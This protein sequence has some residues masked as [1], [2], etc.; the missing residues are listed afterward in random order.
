MPFQDLNFD[1][2]H[3]HI[4]K[5]IQQTKNDSRFHFNHFLKD[6][7]IDFLVSNSSYSLSDIDSNFPEENKLRTLSKGSLGSKNRIECR[8]YGNSFS[9][10]NLVNLE[11]LKNVEKLNVFVKQNISRKENNEILNSSIQEKNRSKSNSILKS[12]N[13]R[14]KECIG[15]IKSFVGNVKI[16]IYYKILN[17]NKEISIAKSANRDNLQQNQE[18]LKFRILNLKDDINLVMKVICDQYNKLPVLFE[19]E[20][21]VTFEYFNQFSISFENKVSHLI[22]IYELFWDSNISNFL[23][24][25]KSYIKK[26]Q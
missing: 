20:D 4:L 21:N 18:D 1:N 3:E 13:K 11:N 8:N 17:I 2:H 7:N 14:S 19:D 16:D 10:N 22:Y 26:N 23:N 24:N 25:L 6:Y 9:I 12:L 5:L 15:R